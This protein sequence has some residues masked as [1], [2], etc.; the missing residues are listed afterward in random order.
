ML[1]QVIMYGI[2]LAIL[3]AL[4]KYFEYSYFVKSF[5]QEV[6]IGIIAVFFTAF[7][8]WSA[9]KW[10][11]HKEAPS[12]PAQ[13]NEEVQLSLEVSDREL[14]VLIN[15]SKGLSNKEIAEKLFL[16]ESTIKTHSSNLFAKLNVNRRTQAV[17]RAREL[18]LIS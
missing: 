14:E 6:Y 8:I 12:E 7:G 5:S 3:I 10:I 17:L 18:G 1:K 13:S 4:L 11:K 9:L 16:S 2:G 15:I